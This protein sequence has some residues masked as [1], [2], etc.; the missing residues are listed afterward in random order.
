MN[1]ETRDFDTV[2][3]SEGGTPGAGGIDALSARFGAASAAE[4]PADDDVAEARS[5]RS[6][7]DRFPIRG[8]D[9][10][11]V[12]LAFALG[13]VLFLVPMPYVVDSPGP[14]FNVVGQYRGTPLISISGTDPTTGKEVS[15]DA[16]HE[17]GDGTGEIR[18]VT[19]SEQGGPGSR[20]NL[21]QLISAWFDSTAKITPYDQV[22]S[23]DVTGKDVETAQSSMMRSSQSTAE[24]AALAQLGWTIP[25]KVTIAGAVKGS[26]A[27]SKVKSGDVLVSMTD[28][29]GT[30]HAI[31]TPGAVFALVKTVP[32]GTTLDLVVERDGKKLTIP[33]TTMSGGEGTKGSKLG[34]YLDVAV[35]LPVTISFNL[36]D[37][38]GP[39]A[40]M[41]FALGIIDRLTPG[42]LAGGATIAG[43]GTMSYDGEVGAIGGIVQ[44]MNGAKRDGATYFL[45]PSS[46]CDEVVGHVPD[47]LR[48]VSVSTLDEAVK[49]VKAI[50]AGEGASLPTCEAA[51]AQS[52]S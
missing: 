20:L 26:D 44:K 29:E 30:V 8:R 14:T 35:D 11:V 42:D 27:A 51:S 23:S 39:S 18:M 1:D 15:L 37:V 47:G 16:V 6:W 33:V 12:A 19:V 46:N 10:L 50:A 48:V 38:G 34:L 40:G 22:Y 41:M 45:A 7:R 36:K 2:P 28:A 5:R 52:G 24:A 9:V 17:N 4:R 21:V 31:D 49:S 25:A 32:V 13:V 3:D 43:T